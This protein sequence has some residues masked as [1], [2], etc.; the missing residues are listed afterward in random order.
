MKESDIMNEMFLNWHSINLVSSPSFSINYA[1]LCVL[2]H[3]YELWFLP[4]KRASQYYLFPVA[5]MTNTTD[6]IIALHFLIVL[7]ATGLREI[8][9]GQN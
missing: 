2:Y 4:A 3:L 5:S 8:L 1:I 7:K 6:V 9:L